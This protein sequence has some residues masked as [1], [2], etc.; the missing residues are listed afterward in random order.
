MRRTLRLLRFTL[1]E[2]LV[3]I[4]I[5]AILAGMLLPALN[6]SRLQAAKISCASNLHQVALMLNSYAQT[7]AGCF[8]AFGMAP[9]WGVLD[10]YGSWGWT[11][12]LALVESSKNP[13]GLKKVF[14]CPKETTRL[15]SYSMN[16]RQVRL[17]GRN[18]FSCWYESEISKA[19]VSPG[20]M[21]MVEESKTTSFNRTDCDQDNYSTNE[22]GIGFNN[23]RHG[24]T[25]IL[26]ADGHVDAAPIFDSSRMTY[27]TNEMSDFK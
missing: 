20:R 8:P 7:S 22:T 5:I 18:N 12:R 24:Q 11:Y 21:I 23:F 14:T 25:N 27:F 26:F 19:S 3:V 2:L 6:S 16:T 1:I 9:E 13:D 10:E 17:M 15:F 4:A